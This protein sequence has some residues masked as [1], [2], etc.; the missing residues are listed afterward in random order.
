M[1]FRCCPAYLQFFVYSS[2]FSAL[3][4][5]SSSWSLLLLIAA[6]NRCII[7]TYK[8]LKIFGNVLINLNSS[9]TVHLHALLSALFKINLLIVWFHLPVNVLCL[10]AEASTLLVSQ[11]LQLSV[12]LKLKQKQVS[13]VWVLHIRITH[14]AIVPP[15]PE[16]IIYGW[17]FVKAKFLLQPRTIMC[18]LNT[19]LVWTRKTIFAKTDLILIQLDIS[20]TGDFLTCRLLVIPPAFL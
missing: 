8:I 7:V 5:K 4:T 12:S 11:L 17:C 2:S 1:Q 19:A 3:L 20:L 16:S 18:A 10:L 9:I 14:A 6:Y 15:S 13:C